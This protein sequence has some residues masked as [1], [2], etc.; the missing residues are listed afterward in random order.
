[1]KVGVKEDG[2][3]V[4]FQGEAWGSG[5]NRGGLGARNLPY[6]FGANLPNSIFKQTGISINGGDTRA[7][8]APDHPQMCLLTM[9]ALADAAAELGMDELEFF[10]KNL[11]FTDREQ[12]YAEE[13]AIA[14]ELIDWKKKWRGRGEQKGVLRRGLGLAIHTWGGSPGDSN[15]QCTLHPDG[16][17]ELRCGTQDLGPGSRTVI[18]IVAAETFGLPIDKVKVLI[19]ES[20]YPPSGASGGSTTTGGVSTATRHACV[21]ALNKLCE[22][23][24]P[25]LDA[26]SAELSAKG[27]QLVAANGKTMAFADAC[28]RLGTQPVVTMGVKQDKLANGQVG[29]AQ[30]AEV[31]VDTETGIVRVLKIVAVQDCGRIIDLL[32]AESQVRGAMI[33]GVCS[34]L[35]EERILDPVTGTLLNPD[36]EFYKLAGIADVG[37]LVVHIMDTPEH[38]NRGVIGIGEPPVISPMA[39]I[40]NAVAN[41]IGARVK[42]CPMTPDR[43]LAALKA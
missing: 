11:K 38:Q 21:Q 20:I 18:A 24:A 31:E 30:M 36:L 39:A 2:E 17:V 7:W 13:L 19:G 26:K 9:A 32:T 35:Y 8:R 37:E 29:G 43:V 42:R 1:M 14:A 6:V 27:G 40:S 41:A 15:V 3:I 12:V 23:I 16:G 28:R 34:A 25:E 10:Q 22:A 5:G 4:A 33:M